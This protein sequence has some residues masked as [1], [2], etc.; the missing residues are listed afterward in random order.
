MS[1]NAALIRR[2][3]AIVAWMAMFATSTL[4]HG[5]SQA[6][7]QAPS[8]G[9]G[10][11][12]GA[13]WVAGGSIGTA[14][15]GSDAGYGDAGSA[16]A[17]AGFHGRPGQSPRPLPFRPSSGPPTYPP[18]LWRPSEPP[19]FGL[20]LPR[21]YFDGRYSHEHLAPGYGDKK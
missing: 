10:G 16:S 2:K 4:L 21:P 11:G 18:P 20:R 3:P 15:L 8:P 1:L 5:P 17:H 7:T 13:G 6:W 19:P 14:V 12:F 9:A